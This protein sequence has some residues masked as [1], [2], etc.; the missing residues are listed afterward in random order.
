M[1]RGSA[2][3]RLRNKIAMLRG[4]LWLV[5]AVMTIG[6]GVIAY[7]VL[8]YGDALFGG[9]G[10]TPW[11][12][13]SGDA[14]TARELLM[15]FLAGMITMTS[16]VVSVT[17]VILT[18]AASQ[19]GPRLITFFMA[20]RQIQFVLG[21]FLSTTFYVII[22]LRTLNDTLGAEGV[23]HAAITLASLLTI[24]CLFALLF[25]VHKIARSVMADNLVREVWRSLRG[26][27]RQILG[28][29]E[30]PEAGSADFGDM[31]RMG[32]AFG[33]CGYVQIIDYGALVKVAR[34]DDCFIE[35]DLRA[36]HYVLAAS[37]RVHVRARR[38][39]AEETLA[40]VRKAFVIGEERTPAQ[41][42]EHGLRQL[43][44]IAL[45]AL[46]A[47]INDPYTAVA[48][49]DHLGAALAEIF[50]HSLPARALADEHGTV[51]VMANRSDPQG[52]LSAA[53][54]QIRQAGQGQPEILMRM[55]SII[56][57][58]GAAAPTMDIRAALRDHLD[59]LRESVETVRLTRA[60][61]QATQAAIEAAREAIS[62]APLVQLRLRPG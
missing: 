11:W 41:D 48:V 20:D 45:R 28:D 29:E 18:T 7:L 5:P 47:G 6:S 22:V 10:D 39:P 32:V 34:A 16:L 13:F 43:V 19:L 8:I 26:D 60:D 3:P 62:S 31:G 4:Q 56:G 46:S 38:P 33:R 35:C 15:G 1:E 12:L 51:R 55:A 53:F 21:L 36:G 30:W 23:P 17:F 59:K 27:I 57:D 61:A 49:I 58:L 25:Y 37:R 9:R 14:A 24:S 54:D 42:L 44:E 52:L 50:A 2:T 40:K